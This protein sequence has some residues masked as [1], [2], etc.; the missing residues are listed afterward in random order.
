MFRKFGFA[1]IAIIFGAGF[2]FASYNIIAEIK[3]K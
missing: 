2:S 3:I 1:F